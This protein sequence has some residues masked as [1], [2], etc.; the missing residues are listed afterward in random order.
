[1]Q[2]VKMYTTGTCPYCIRAKQVLRGKGV[3]ELEEIR[4]DLDPG[5]WD[6]VSGTFTVSPEQAAADAA[7]RIARIRDHQRRQAQAAEAAVAAG[8]V[9]VVRSRRGF[10]VMVGRLL[11]GRV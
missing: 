5:A 7:S 2:A 1:M 4:V 11:R 3:N 6:P 10:H 9:Q 8:V